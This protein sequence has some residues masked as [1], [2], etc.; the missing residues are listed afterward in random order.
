[1]GQQITNN[2]LP[3]TSFAAMRCCIGNWLL[4]IGYSLFE[5][6]QTNE[7]QRFVPLE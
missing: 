4:V 6:A 3:I 5:Q 7:P 1:M 2:K